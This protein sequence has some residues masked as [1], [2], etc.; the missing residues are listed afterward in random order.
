MYGLSIAAAVVTAVC[1]LLRLITSVA[2]IDQLFDS[3]LL[4]VYY[5]VSAWSSLCCVLLL[6]LIA[7]DSAPTTGYVSLT[8]PEGA[9]ISKRRQERDTFDGE[10]PS[11]CCSLAVARAVCCVAFAAS[12]A[13]SLLAVLMF[14]RFASRGYGRYENTRYLTCRMDAVPSAVANCSCL[15]PLGAATMGLL[16]TAQSDPQ[17]CVSSD[18]LLCP[19]AFAVDSSRSLDS[20]ELQMLWRPTCLVAPSCAAID[21]TPDRLGLRSRPCQV[22][23]QNCTFS[24]Y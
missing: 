17:V 14:A 2:L 11:C 19:S 9:L 21:S 24:S 3:G 18:R 13:L 8:R 23:V 1:L 7:S 12:L 4:G 20:A 22:V 10:P 5:L 16:C 6:S 15:D